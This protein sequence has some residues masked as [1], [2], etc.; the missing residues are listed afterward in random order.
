MWVRTPQEIHSY[1][2][3]RMLSQDSPGDTLLYVS[4]DVV[5]DVQLRRDDDGRPHFLGSALILNK[6]EKVIG[7]PAFTSLSASRLWM[8]HNLCLAFLP[9]CLPCQGSQQPSHYEIKPTLPALSCFC[10]MLCHSNGTSN[11]CNPTQTE[12]ENRFWEVECHQNK[13]LETWKPL[14]H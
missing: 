2:S 1:M 10:W 12:A 3:L 6:E 8:Q 11:W 5:R 14:W 7:T 4:E 9:P 13:C